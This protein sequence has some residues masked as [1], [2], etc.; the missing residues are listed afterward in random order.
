MAVAIVIALVVMAI[1][2]LAVMTGCIS[3]V[4]VGDDAY[5][6]S[7]SVVVRVR[8]VVVVVVHVHATGDAASARLVVRLLLLLPLGVLHRQRVSGTR[9][10][11]LGGGGGEC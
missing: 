10:L 11:A 3:Y 5:G 9:V 7:Y 6:S 1:V 2:A 4:V 8:V